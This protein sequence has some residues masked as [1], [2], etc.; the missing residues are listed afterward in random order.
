MNQRCQ[1]E[2]ELGNE[3]SL[4]NLDLLHSKYEESKQIAGKI[5]IALIIVS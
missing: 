1:S 3:N 2:E 4:R 5:F